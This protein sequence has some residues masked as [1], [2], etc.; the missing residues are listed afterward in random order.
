MSKAYVAAI[1]VPLTQDVLN[2]FRADLLEVIQTRFLPNLLL[3]FSGLELMDRSEFIGL[4]SIVKMAYLMGVDSYYVRLN[5][6]IAA[7]LVHMGVEVDEIKTAL[8]LEDAF[9]AIESRR[10]G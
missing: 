9:A 2:R 6:R 3:D 5:P 1:Q 7:A 8:N 4:N 10:T